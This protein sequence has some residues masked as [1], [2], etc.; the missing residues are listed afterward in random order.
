MIDI[1]KTNAL[2][3]LNTHLMYKYLTGSPFSSIIDH[4]SM[5]AVPFFFFGE[6]AVPFYITRKE[7]DSFFWGH[8]LISG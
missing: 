3:L 8:R 1:T 5:I 2:L 7:A 4:Q 6:L